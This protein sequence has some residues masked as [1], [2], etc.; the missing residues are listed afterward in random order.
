MSPEAISRGSLR[1]ENLFTVERAAN[2]G[3]C[4]LWVNY[5]GG[6]Y[7]IPQEGAANT[8]RVLGL[9]AQLLALSTSVRDI[10]FTPSVRVLQ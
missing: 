9:L 10:G 8:K 3:G 7:C 5:A 4:F 1:D 6:S 2:A